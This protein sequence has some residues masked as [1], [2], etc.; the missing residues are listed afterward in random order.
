MHIHRYGRLWPHAAWQRHVDE[1]A[2]AA[3]GADANAGQ[4]APR[5]DIREEAER[6]VIHA[7]LPGVDPQT[8]DIQMDQGVL[9]I[10]GERARE[11]VADG[12]QVTRSERRHGRFHRRFAL[13]DSADAEGISASGR[14]GVLEVVIPKKP[15]TTPRRIQVGVAEGSPTVQ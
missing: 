2:R 15:Q 6:F 5:V 9:S 10:Q 7:D 11:T 1:A 13:P 4:W 12:V 3:H 14:N 8:I